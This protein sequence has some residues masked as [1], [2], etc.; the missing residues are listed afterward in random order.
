MVGGGTALYQMYL[1]ERRKDPATPIIPSLRKMSGGGAPMPPEI[2][3]E[4]KQEFGVKICHGY[5]MTECPMICEAHRTTPTSSWPTPSV[6]RSRAR[7]ADRD[8]GRLGRR[9]RRGRRPPQGAMVFKG[10]TDAPPPPRR[11]TTTGGSAPA[12]WATCAP[13]ATS[14]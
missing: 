5:G 13:T 7:P 3:D 8:R 1:T 11:S 6:N 2:F 12:T 9:T 10:Y 14:C 4:V